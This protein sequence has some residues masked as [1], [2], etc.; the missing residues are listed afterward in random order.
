MGERSEIEILHDE[1]QDLAEEALGIKKD[2]M[3][4]FGKDYLPEGFKQECWSIASIMMGVHNAIRPAKDVAVDKFRQM[5]A[6]VNNAA[7]RI[8][9]FKTI[10]R[11]EEER[12]M[13]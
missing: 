4:L 6:D 10:Y 1:I 13:K 9:F 5:Q 3:N 2:A 8:K 12:Y 7:I 11:Q